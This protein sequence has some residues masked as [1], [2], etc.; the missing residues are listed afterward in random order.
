MACV[1]ENSNAHRVLVG[2][3]EVQRLFRGRGGRWEDNIEIDLKEIRWE[4]EDLIDVVQDK[5]VSGFCDH[6]NEIS[7]SIKCR[8]CLTGCSTAGCRGRTAA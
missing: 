3:P 8:K 2:K 7:C 1:W 4:A 5:D 6:R